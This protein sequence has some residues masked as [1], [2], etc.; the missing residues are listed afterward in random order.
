MKEG[1]KWLGQPCRAWF[2]WAPSLDFVWAQL[3]RRVSLLQSKPSSRSKSEKTTM[4]A[5]LFFFA[6]SMQ[7]F[8]A[9]KLWTCV[10][11]HHLFAFDIG[12]FDLIVCILIVHFLINLVQVIWQR[13]PQCYLKHTCF[14]FQGV[15]PYTLVPFTDIVMLRT[16][17]FG[18]LGMTLFSWYSLRSKL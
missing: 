5:I 8:S 2:P 1:N 17:S 9:G 18:S 14:F 3:S 4:H 10:V 6:K 12:Q 13:R 11:E 16:I 15:R 7:F